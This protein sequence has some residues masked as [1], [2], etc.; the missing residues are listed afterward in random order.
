MKLGGNEDDDRERMKQ[1]A[2][3]PID[4]VVDIMP[5][6]VPTTTV[7]AALMTVRPYGRAVLMGGVGMLGGSGLELPDPWIMRSCISI[8]GAWMCPPEA[9]IRL[10][11]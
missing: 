3:G 1:A 11:G 10:S 4:C 7:R 8:H 6:S 9:A 2:S 5:L